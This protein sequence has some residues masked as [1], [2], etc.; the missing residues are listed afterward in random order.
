[1]WLNAVTKPTFKVRQRHSVTMETAT[2]VGGVAQRL[3][4]TMLLLLS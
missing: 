1:M 2:S 3:V 4:T